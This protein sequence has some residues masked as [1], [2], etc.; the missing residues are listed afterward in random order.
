MTEKEE[1][2][3]IQAI[4]ESRKLFSGLK[5]ANQMEIYDSLAN[6]RDILNDLLE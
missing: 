2:Q 4:N 1:V 5:P 3:I 6:L